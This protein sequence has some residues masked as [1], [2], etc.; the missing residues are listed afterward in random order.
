MAKRI[1]IVLI[2]ASFVLYG[3]IFAVPFVGVSHSIKAGIVTAL[4]VLGE[5]TFW[6][7][8]LLVGREVVKKYRSI[9]KISNWFRKEKQPESGE[10]DGNG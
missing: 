6:V 7:G 10:R 3:L 4:V 9:F 5:A 1:G 8:G 2:I